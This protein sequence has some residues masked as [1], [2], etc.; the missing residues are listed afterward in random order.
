MK[1]RKIRG[2]ERGG[3]ERRKGQGRNRGRERRGKDVEGE[4]MRNIEAK[5]G[6]R[7]NRRKNWERMEGDS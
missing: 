4:R 5:K 3:R 7:A 1:C 2:R 6:R